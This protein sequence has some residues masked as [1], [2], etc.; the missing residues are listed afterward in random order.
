MKGAGLNACFKIFF[1]CCLVILI[2][3]LNCK[4]QRPLTPGDAFYAVRKAL[5]INDLDAVMDILSVGSIEKI[6]RTV[7]VISAMNDSQIR[8]FSGIYGI[9]PGEIKNFSAKRFVELYFKRRDNIIYKAVKEDIVSID[10]EGPKAL[11]RV[12]NGLM[13][14]FVREG[15]YWKLDMSNF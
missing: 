12:A 6:K 13:I 9:V 11:I 14:D 5:L 2:S 3:G 8:A 4:S 7:K 1:F 10:V 15:P